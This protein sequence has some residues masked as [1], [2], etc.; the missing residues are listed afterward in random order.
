MTREALSFLTCLLYLLTWLSGGYPDG[1]TP[2]QNWPVLKF[3]A[4]HH[5]L[6][7]SWRGWGSWPNEVEWCRYQYA[8]LKDAPRLAEIPDVPDRARFQWAQEASRAT[9]AGFDV[10]LALQPWNL[11]L[12]AARGEA[13]WLSCFWQDAETATCRTGLWHVRRAAAKRAVGRIGRERFL[14]GDW[15][16]PA[17][18]WFFERK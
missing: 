9:I 13:E 10:R 12:R 5:E 7:A 14:A 2:Q 4:R 16:P 15:P 17:P 1:P 3:F 8:E 18:L 6:W 11:D